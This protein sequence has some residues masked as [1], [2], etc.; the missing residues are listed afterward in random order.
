MYKLYL[1]IFKYA[2]SYFTKIK[3]NNKYKSNEGNLV[4][5]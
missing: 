3:E 1:D 5:I 4:Y 2:Q